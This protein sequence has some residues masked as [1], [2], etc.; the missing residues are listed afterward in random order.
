ME[1]E[2]LGAHL[3][4]RLKQQNHFSGRKMCCS[5]RPRHSTALGSIGKN[6]ALMRRAELKASSARGDR[7][8]C[9]DDR[10][11]KREDENTAK[12]ER[13][14]KP[15]ARSTVGEKELWWR[16]QKTDR[17]NPRRRS[18][19]IDRDRAAHEENQSATGS[20]KTKK[21]KRRS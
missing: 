6:E 3:Q 12:I 1:T 14:Q 9:A 7:D 21:E 11:H 20:S 16:A 19:K 5:R 13:Q 10:I 2:S 8:P 17:G 18:K 4:Q 15:W